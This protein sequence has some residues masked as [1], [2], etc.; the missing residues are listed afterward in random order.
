[1][2]KIRERFTFNISFIDVINILT[3]GELPAHGHGASTTIEGQHHHSL[4]LER[5]GGSTYRNDVGWGGDHTEL[6][7]STQTT[8]DAGAHNHKVTINNTGSSQA[9]NNIQ[10]YI[11]VYMWKRTA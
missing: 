9:H 7:S 3:V 1:M 2:I 4:T 5:Y 8:T 6:G 10:P 11:A